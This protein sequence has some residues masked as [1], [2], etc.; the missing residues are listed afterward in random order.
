MEDYFEIHGHEVLNGDVTKV[1]NGAHV[2]V[3][4]DWLGADVKVVRTSEP[5]PDEE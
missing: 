4:K 1:G 3:P 2:L 5:D